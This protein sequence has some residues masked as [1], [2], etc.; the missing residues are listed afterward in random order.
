MSTMSPTVSK[1]L[2]LVF[3]ALA[4]MAAAVVHVKFPQLSGATTSLYVAAGMLTG[5][6][7]MAPGAVSSQA[8]A[9]LQSSADRH[10]QLA[11]ALSDIVSVLVAEI[12]PKAPAAPPPLP[13]TPSVPDT[14]PSAAPV[15]S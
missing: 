2:F 15:V 10:A 12:R 14:T 7:I 4:A 9:S 13:V 5:V 6:P 1:A 11:L 3:G 8:V